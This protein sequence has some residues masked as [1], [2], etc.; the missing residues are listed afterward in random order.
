MLRKFIV[1]LC[2]V[3]WVTDIVSDLCDGTS[4][5]DD[6]SPG[7]ELVSKSGRDSGRFGNPTGDGGRS[8][9]APLTLAEKFALYQP[10]HLTYS[11]SRRIGFVVYGREIFSLNQVLL[12]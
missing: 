6:Y 11:L 2:L 4:P 7:I 9:F 3:L 10:Q 5:L 8:I 12:I 1:S